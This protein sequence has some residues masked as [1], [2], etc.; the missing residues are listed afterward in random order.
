MRNKEQAG[1]EWAETEQPRPRHKTKFIVILIVVLALL[2]CAG[3]W[4]GVEVAGGSGN[5]AAPS[6]YIA[7]YM[8]TGDVYFGKPNWFPSLSL[9]NAL[10]LQRSTDQT[11]K[12]QIGIAPFSGVFWQP[13]GDIH[14]NGQQILFWASI[15]KGSQI[16]QAIENP[17]SLT[18]QQQQAPASAGPAATSTTGSNK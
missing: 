9:T 6:G 2:L 17:A 1:M 4:I 8:T 18:N 16:V 13:V 3:V 5:S 7:V 12:T 15:S 10:Y 11:G 14:L